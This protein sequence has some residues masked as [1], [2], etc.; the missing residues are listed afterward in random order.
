MQSLEAQRHLGISAFMQE[1]LGP[2][3]QYVLARCTNDCLSLQR[4]SNYRLYNRCTYITGLDSMNVDSM[5]S[6]SK[7]EAVLSV[8]HW[9]PVFPISFADQKVVWSAS[10]R[11]E[12]FLKKEPRNNS[13]D[14]GSDSSSWEW[15]LFTTSHSME[16]DYM[17][18]IQTLT[19][20]SHVTLYQLI[21]LS[22]RQFCHL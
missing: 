21:N 17:A 22:G 16:Q 4:E 5:N 12:F 1:T 9:D 14:K 18:S 13:V 15:R 3:H 2:F 7:T 10:F 6:A 19:L 8:P 20:I 11:L